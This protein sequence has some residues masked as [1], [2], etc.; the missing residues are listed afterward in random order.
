[1]TKPYL[2]IKTAD[3]N[4]IQ[5]VTSQADVFAEDWMFYNE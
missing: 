4:R 1:M 2:F 5:W 3:D